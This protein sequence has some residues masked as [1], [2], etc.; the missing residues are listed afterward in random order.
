[1]ELVDDWG[2]FGQVVALW[3]PGSAEEV[4]S[5]DEPVLLASGG[6]S[7]Y[8]EHHGASVLIDQS[9][10]EASGQVVTTTTWLSVAGGVLSG[11]GGATTPCVGWIRH[12]AIES[13]HPS[14]DAQPEF[15]QLSTLIGMDYPSTLEEAVGVAQAVAMGEPPDFGDGLKCV[16]KWQGS[17]GYNCCAEFGPYQRSVAACGN[18]YW[19]TVWTCVGATGG[20]AAICM[21]ACLKIPIG[22]TPFGLK[23]CAISCGIIVGVGLIACIMAARNAWKACVNLAGRDY[24]QRLLDNGCGEP[25][26]SLAPI[27]P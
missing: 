27:V 7:P 2:E 22:G 23:V 25:P 1:M 9:V 3:G 12:Q 13:Y 20:V 19:S 4:G 16:S 10:D 6:W 8:F 11:E 26:P 5:A 21:G 18:S 24:L 15:A 14:G 17:G